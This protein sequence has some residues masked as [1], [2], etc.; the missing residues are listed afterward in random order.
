MSDT[1]PADVPEVFDFKLYRYNPSLPAA[2]TAVIVFTILT[3]LHVW[4]LYK[5]RAKY[6]IAFTL[7]GACKSSPSSSISFNR[8]LIDM[9][10]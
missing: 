4:R 3:V 5:A 2:I 1:G 7:G 9:S 8:T 10:K 6:F